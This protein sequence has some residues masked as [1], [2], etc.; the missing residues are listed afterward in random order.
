M[1]TSFTSG[2]EAE[3]Q[4]WSTSLD[5]LWDVIC[6]NNHN[7]QINRPYFRKYLGS[8]KVRIAYISTCITTKGSI[9]NPQL[10]LSQSSLQGSS[11]L[12]ALA[13]PSSFVGHGLEL[14]QSH[15]DWGSSSLPREPQPFPSL[16]LSLSLFIYFLY[17]LLIL[18]EEGRRMES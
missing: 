17:V 16:P 13:L 3:S 1:L 18:Q 9:L 7:P 6:G 4:K 5:H 12:P 11:A 2:T 15:P 14:P 8:S 10:V